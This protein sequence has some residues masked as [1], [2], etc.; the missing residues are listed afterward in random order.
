MAHRQRD[1]QTYRLTETDIQRSQ[2][3]QYRDRD[4][5][6]YRQTETHI[7]GQAHTYIQTNIQSYRHTYR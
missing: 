7:Y 2:T 5:Y 1:N 4:I 6:T 3:D